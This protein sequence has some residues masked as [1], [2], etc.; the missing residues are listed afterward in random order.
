MI[1]ALGSETPRMRYDVIIVGSGPAG[2][3]TALNLHRIAPQV[4]RRTLVLERD[5][6]PRH[7]LCGGACT[8]DV[9]ACLQK[10]GLDASEVPQRKVDW[11]H[12][13]YQG[14]GFR[15]RFFADHS[16]RVVRRD[17]FDGWL[18]RNV[19][20]TGVELKEETRVLALRCVE[21]GVEVE[22]NRGAFSAPVVVGAD[23]ASSLVRRTV[24][25]GAR[26]SNVARLVDVLTPSEPH[27]P[28]R[29]IKSGDALLEFAWMP[30]GIQGYAW[31][32]PTQV[33]GTPMRNWGIYDSRVLH[34]RPIGG[35]LRSVVSEWLA[36]KGFRLDNFELQGHPIRLF[37]RRDRFSSPHLLLVGDAAGVDAVFGEGISLALG[38]GELAAQAISDAFARNDFTFADYRQRVLASPLGR[39]LRWRTW[40]ARQ[41]NRLSHPFFQKLMWRH[42]G[43][44]ITWYMKHVLFNWA[45]P[46]SAPVGYGEGTRP[47]PAA[48]PAARPHFDMPRP[49]RS[50]TQR[51]L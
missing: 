47:V 25:K 4:A 20:D 43:P 23:G 18:A 16:F 31:S 15:M 42:G 45:A 50:E 36:G 3:S 35:S 51:Q 37:D 13:Q 26:S 6:H 29:A 8:P 14:R 11:A 1:G 46:V 24:C 49:V 40:T 2:S 33:H 19:C 10:L 38:Y 27:D 48:E 30:R 39:S 34:K 32:F 44:V 17:E 21:G 9:Y 22:T 28:S 12:L 7:K 41:I 5:R